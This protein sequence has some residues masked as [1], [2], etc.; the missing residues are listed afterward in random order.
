MRVEDRSKMWKRNLAIHMYISVS[1]I[2]SECRM[3]CDSVEHFL[4]QPFIKHDPGQIQS[5]MSLFDVRRGRYRFQLA[6]DDNRVLRNQVQVVR[7]KIKNLE[8]W[9]LRWL[10]HRRLWSHRCMDMLGLTWVWDGGRFVRNQLDSL[11]EAG[12]REWLKRWWK[13]ILEEKTENRKTDEHI[14]E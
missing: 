9:D 10:F 13:R 7:H 14:D 11:N 1:I 4:I 5:Q 12:Q 8:I 2:H 6:K 3:V